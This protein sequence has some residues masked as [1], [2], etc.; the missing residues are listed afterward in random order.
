MGP[1]A[2]IKV[3]EMKG[4]GPGPYAG[5]LLA[6]MG[7]DVIVVERAS[8]STGLAL[9]SSHDV[10][11]RGKRSIALDLK[12]PG[13]IDVL[14]RLVEQA[15]M[16]L[17]GYRPGVAE[18]LGFGPAVCQQKNPQLIYGRVTGWGQD[19]PL[20]TAAGHDINYIALTGALAAIGEPERPVP[21][22]NLLG[23]YAGGSLFLVLGMLA[24][25]I[26][27][28]TSGQGQVIDAAI[29]D[30]TASL[31]SVVHGLS[32]MG[33]WTAERGSNLLDGAAP[34]YAVYQ[35][36]D[37]KHV[38]IGAL[39]PVFLEELLT[40]IGA[41]PGIAER[42]SDQR[43]WPHIKEQL[44]AIFARQ[45]QQEWCERLEG[46]DACFAPVLNFEEAAAHPHNS[47][48]RTYINIA[49]QQQPAPAPRFSRSAGG[50]PA[51]PRREGADTDQ[52]LLQ[53]GLS[54][55]EIEALRAAGVLG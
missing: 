23:D 45:S 31:M 48:R 52:V 44:A 12:K 19:G 24:A 32:G 11:A 41:D 18:R 26:E 4:L 51:P 9:A 28:K 22:L 50:E 10:H 33:L 21:P 1:L 49:G 36:S 8:A 17:E 29:T 39:E 2:G 46:S 25:Y 43:Q 53:A 38:S 30:G 7:A 40:I 55:A 35:T 3:I 5:M 47:A 37:G 15:D 20:A 14:L 6:D 34:Q 27:S 16:L 54:A 42:L 13:A